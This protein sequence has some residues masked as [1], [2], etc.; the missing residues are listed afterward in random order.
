MLEEGNPDL[1]YS[2]PVTHK[3]PQMVMTRLRCSS[4]FTPKSHLTGPSTAAFNALSF[5]VKLAVN[6]Q[7]LVLKPRLLGYSFDSARA[8][9][10]MEW[11]ADGILGNLKLVN[12]NDEVVAKFRNKL[13]SN[14][15]LGIFD[16]FGAVEDAL[17]DEIVLS[18]LAVLAM[19]QSVNL[20]AMVLAGKSHKK[21]S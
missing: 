14:N 16:I 5:E 11:K 6:G 4:P 9:S 12:E 7:D 1:L 21:M 18:G 3:T 15:E 20:G 2:V 17:V 19:A 10:K 13:F 8:G